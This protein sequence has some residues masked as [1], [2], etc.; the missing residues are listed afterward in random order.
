[1][2]SRVLMTHCFVCIALVSCFAAST[3]AQDPQPVTFPGLIP[4]FGRQTPQGAAQ[5]P[6]GVATGDFNNDGKADIVIT[7]YETTAPT[8]GN[9]VTV[10]PGNGDGTFQTALN[11]TVGTNPI[12]V[13]V[14]DFNGDGNLDLA[15][16]NY[17]SGNVS[18]LLGN[19]DFTFQNAVNYSVGG[20]P[21]AIVVGDLNGDGKL[22][23]IV[24]DSNGFVV[25]PGNGD[26]TFGNKL[27][28]STT[29]GGVEYIAVGDFNGDGKLDLVTTSTNAQPGYPP[30][31]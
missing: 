30:V 24:S 23:L 6:W 3:L 5:E 26:G 1:M 13:V 21:N 31:M 12:G 25:L 10:V 15:V 16:A 19:G 8:A 2:R 9:T 4:V 28:Y 17:G 14:A 18:V 20:A 27:V 7:N 29:Y 22:D 11:Y